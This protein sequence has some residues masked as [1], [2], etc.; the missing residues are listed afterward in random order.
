MSYTAP[1]SDPSQALPRIRCPHLGSADDRH[2]STLYP[3]PIG[4]CYRV[5]P[6]EAIDLDHQATHCLTAEYGK[7]PVLQ[8]ENLTRLPKEIRRKGSYQYGSDQRPGRL[9]GLGSLLLL[10]LLGG[11]IF[12]LARDLRL[13]SRD[14]EPAAAAIPTTATSTFT[15]TPLPTATQRPSATPRPSSS[16][17][18]TVTL[19]PTLT[20]TPSP[21]PTRTAT[22][23]LTPGAITVVAY[24]NTAGV[25]IRT[26]PHLSYPIAWVIEAE[27]DELTVT[28]QTEAGDWFQVCC[29][30]EQV[31]W[32]ASE[33]IT[34]AG[35]L[36]AVPIIPLP[37]PSVAILP[38]RVNLRSGPGI[39]YPVLAVVEQDTEFEIVSSYQ[40]GLWWEIC[41]VDGLTGWLIGESVV[42]YGAT[43]SVPE[44]VTIPPTPTFTPEPV[45]PTVS[46]SE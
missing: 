11:M 13:N 16:S 35:E 3:S 14:D 22:P 42:V 18:V 20:P 28:G 1:Y 6:H 8:Q 39:V 21:Q 29:Q 2:T 12:L 38:G 5:T 23:T 17:T 40:G 24:T 45:V 32:A 15:P 43:E 34:V 37:S 4:Y 30:E 9:R 7:C 27:G 31:G 41:C 19:A 44:A 25:N 10:G 26:G 33:T 36:A 46:S